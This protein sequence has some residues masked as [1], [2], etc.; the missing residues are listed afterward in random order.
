MKYQIHFAAVATTAALLFSSPLPRAFAQETTAPPPAAP[1]V[2]LKGAERLRQEAQ[3]LSALVKGS[4]APRFLKAA[5]D[6]PPFVPRNLYRDPETK[7]LLTQATADKWE[8]E[9]R[10]SLVTVP[11][12]ENVYYN[13]S[14]GSPLAYARPLEVLESEAG[15]KDLKGKK[16][17]DF[18]Y[19]TLGHLR[20]FALCGAEVVG[21]DV[22]P[23]LTALYSEP[24]DQGKIGKEGGSVTLVEGQFPASEA[25][26]KA[27]GGGYDLIVSKNTLKN[28]YIHPAEP[29]DK[30]MLVDLGV[31]DKAFVQSLYDILK[32]GGRVL[33]YNLSPAPAPKGQPYLPMA[34]GRS[35]FPRALWEEV[36][37]KVI[38][39]D[40]D[41]NVA[42][43]ALGRA[44]GWDKGSR[45]MDLE[46]GLF[47]HYTLVEKSPP[48][49]K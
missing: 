49:R 20:L 37:F 16:V 45:P 19:G 40:T 18:G 2:V 43:R 23:L 42:A 10:K 9:K 21:V 13:T 14:Y 1:P 22:D 39:F 15:I 48:R 29:V 28:G 33:I 4:L 5:A 31:D 27:V 47:G 26:R 25:V 41:D 34:D 8:E 6:L 11:I 24:G 3:A 30:R 32:P 38:A 17:L 7:A 36:G 35:P 12:S 44:L 46:N